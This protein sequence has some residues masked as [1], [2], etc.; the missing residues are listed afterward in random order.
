M[1][2][3]ELGILSAL[4]NSLAIVPYVYAVVRGSAKPNRVTWII[5]R[6]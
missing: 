6:F 1:T 5:W 4:L 2:Q 3:Q